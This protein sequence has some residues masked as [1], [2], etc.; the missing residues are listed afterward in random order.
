MKRV[1]LSKWNYGGNKKNKK[2]KINFFFFFFF[3]LFKGLRPTLP[4]RPNRVPSPFFSSLLYYQAEH[5]LCNTLDESVYDQAPS[6]PV[7]NSWK[8]KPLSSW[9]PSQRLMFS[10]WLSNRIDYLFWCWLDRLPWYKSLHN[11]LMHISRWCPYF[12]ESKKVRQSFKIINWGKI[13]GL[14]CSM[15]RTIASWPPRGTWF[16]QKLPTPLHADNTNAVWITKNPVFHGR[17]KHRSWLSLY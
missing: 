3:W 4:S 12:M 13:L 10:C 1:K 2:A 11:R 6:S 8:N 17:M 14:V 15:R 7:S 16:T 9:H 5:Q